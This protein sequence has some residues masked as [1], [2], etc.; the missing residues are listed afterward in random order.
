MSWEPH[1]K[2][3]DYTNL[4]SRVVSKIKNNIDLLT[5]GNQEE[6]LSI[7]FLSNKSSTL[8]FGKNLNWIYYIPTI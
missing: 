3:L 7:L 2:T 4:Y 8:G 6:N 5:E 1:Q